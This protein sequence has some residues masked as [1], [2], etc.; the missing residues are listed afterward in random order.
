M[1]KRV[2]MVIGIMIFGFLCLLSGINNN[3]KEATPN[4]YSYDGFTSVTFEGVKATEDIPW[5][6]TAGIFDMDFG[7]S[8]LLTPNTS[9]ELGNMGDSC[10]WSFQYR[11]H[12]WVSENSDGAGLIIWIL[13]SEGNILSADEV[14][15]SNSNDWQDYQVD[16]SSFERASQVKILCNNGLFNN[17]EC[18]WVIIKKMDTERSSSNERYVKSATYFAD[19]W[20]VN[21]WNSELDDLDRDLKRIKSDGFNSIILVIPWRE[22]QPDMNPIRYNESAFSQLDK[23]MKAAEEERLDVYVR[24][25]Y[26]WDYY[27]DANENI[28]DRFCRLLYD[29]Q[30][31]NAWFDYVSKMYSELSQYNNFAEGFLTWEDFWNNL[32]ICDDLEESNR[33]E[34]ARQIGYGKWVEQVYGLELYNTQYGTEYSSYDQIAVPHRDEPAMYAM[35]E[36]YD[37]FLISLLSESQKRFP[38]L[39]M[40]VRLDYDVTYNKEGEIEY[41]KHTDTFSCADSDFTATMYGIPMGFE[42]VGEK[43]SSQEGLIKTEYILS[44]LQQ[45]NDNKAIYVEQFIFADNTPAYRNNAQI[46]DNEISGYL[47]S[48]SDILLKYTA[49]YGI[50]TYRNYQANMIYNPQFALTEEGWKCEGDVQ[51]VEYDDSMA[52]MLDSSSAIFQEIPSIRNHFDS[53]KYKM[54]L[55]VK[56]ITQTGTLRI[57]L[58]D[59]GQTVDVTEEGMIELSIDKNSSFDLKIES[60]EGRFL[61]DDIKLFSQVQE[62]FLYSEKGDELS[63]IESIRLL[64]AQ[65]D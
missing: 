43:V 18:D 9:V 8:I 39:S 4:E 65:L 23:I 56:D 44:Q 5:K 45:Q 19:E 51:F 59:Q 27:N 42:N 37:N 16:F 62:G 33:V 22:F 38:N 12:P 34:R 24:I 61:I 7:K 29:D 26:T 1:K 57:T 53:E 49:G 3:N 21:F 40:E 48:V 11:I 25:G 2:S 35:F 60:L 31:K 14:Q 36:Y 54:S 15:I 20:P 41:Y 55:C 64:N 63:C 58:G 30:A 13:D 28:V 46:K 6:Y 10:S 32:G 17:D 50:W 52:C 47:E